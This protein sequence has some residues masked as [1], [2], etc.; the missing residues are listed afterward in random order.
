MGRNKSQKAGNTLGP[1]RNTRRKN[2]II[3]TSCFILSLDTF[4]ILYLAQRQCDVLLYLDNTYI[5]NTCTYIHTQ[6]IQ[7]INQSTSILVKQVKIPSL[8]KYHPICAVLSIGFHLHK[9]EHNY[10]Q[11]LK[12]TWSLYLVHPLNIH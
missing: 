2:R 9:L 11:I 1:E 5:H 7:A 3:L 10:F 8:T 12:E 6:I 4:K